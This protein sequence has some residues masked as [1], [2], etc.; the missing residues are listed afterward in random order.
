METC[1]YFSIAG[2]QNRRGKVAGNKD[3]IEFVS[4]EN[5]FVSYSEKNRELINW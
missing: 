2:I 4:Y 1:K 3:T 5:M